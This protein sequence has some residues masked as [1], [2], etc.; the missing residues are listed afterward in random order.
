MTTARAN[1]IVELLRERG[2]SDVRAWATSYMKGT[3]PFFGCKMPTTRACV[4]DVVSSGTKKRSR[5][6]SA[7]VSVTS[8]SYVDDAVSLLTHTHGEAKQAGTI[9]LC[10]HEPASTLAT[11]DTL[12]RLEREV[13]RGPEYF[14]DWA[15]TDA[16]ATKVLKKMWKHNPALAPTILAWSWDETTSL[17]HR[18]CGIV[19]FVSYWKEKDVSAL[20]DDFAY[21]IV[22]ACEANLLAAPRERFAQ[23]GTAWVT[24]YALAC[25]DA[26]VRAHALRM[27]TKHS[28]VWT[29]EAKK[30]LVEQ[31]TRDLS[32][33]TRI[34]ELK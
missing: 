4:R 26:D 24:R 6:G 19:A 27:V 5:D 32:T 16:F 21:K 14:N 17:W 8:S 20:P 22:D 9:L 1:A 25:R 28:D 33:A 31:L 23:T 29:T 15:V 7:V 3:T 2:T 30:S 11:M 10:E 34:L 12:R 13:L 18:R